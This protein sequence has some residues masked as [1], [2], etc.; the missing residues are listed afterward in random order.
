[1][2]LSHCGGIEKEW[3]VLN[4]HGFSKI[5]RCHEKGSLLFTFNGGNTIHGGRAW[6]L[7]V[8]G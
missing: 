2:A 7:F 3:E 6:S 1:L 5:E 4:L 8:Y